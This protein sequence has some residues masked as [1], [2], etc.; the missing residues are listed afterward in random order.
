MRIT[1]FGR[2][3]PYFPIVVLLAGISCSGNNPVTPSTTGMNADM[4]LDIAEIAKIP[5]LDDVL[6]A[7]GGGTW[8]GEGI[9][10]CKGFF[11]ENVVCLYTDVEWR[12][13]IVLRVLD[14]E[15]ISGIELTD[16]F[17]AEYSV[18]RFFVTAGE[19]TVE[20]TGGGNSATRV[21]WTIDELPYGAAVRLVL[22]VS[23]RPNPGGN[24]EFTSPGIYDLNPGLDMKWTV[25]GEEQEVEGLHRLTVEAIECD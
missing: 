1:L 3:R 7:S 6:L 25:D 4:P 13:P 16:T 18:D 21:T 11:G 2:A 10:V 14:E 8:V 15:G 20:P 24:Q 12:V 17:P 19:V 22:L 5:N 9:R 23:T